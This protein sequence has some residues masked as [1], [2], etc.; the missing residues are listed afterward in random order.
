VNVL[1]KGLSSAT[2][3]SMV[4]MLGMDSRNATLFV[5]SLF[6]VPSVSFPGFL[7]GWDA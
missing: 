5:A 1:T 7:L 3:Q 2:F 6:D 4:D